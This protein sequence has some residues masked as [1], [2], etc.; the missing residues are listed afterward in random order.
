M[1]I[2]LGSSGC[3]TTARN[4]VYLTNGSILYQFTPATLAFIQVATINCTVNNA[5]LLALSIALQS[6]GLLWVQMLNSI[7]FESKLYTY[8]ISTGICSDVALAA[9][10]STLSSSSI[11]FVKNTTDN[12]ESLYASN[13]NTL[14]K[15][16][17]NSLTVSVVGN[18]TN[19]SSPW[20]L[21]GTNDGKLYGVSY[22]NDG[23]RLTQIDLTTAQS[24][25]QYGLPVDLNGDFDYFS[26][27]P[28]K[29]NFTLLH[30]SENS[31][32][33]ILYNAATNTTTNRTVLSMGGLSSLAVSTC[34][35]T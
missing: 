18:F 7:S 2:I 3:S 22:D 20:D 30:G 32:R 11:A 28:Y 23:T 15:L 5:T 26:Y 35:G 19:G 33:V 9:N 17:T 24:L 6:S 16:N 27:V 21:A 25:S 12:S 31:T 14:K 13:Y 8:N 29:S 34:L 10:Q 4:N 1:S